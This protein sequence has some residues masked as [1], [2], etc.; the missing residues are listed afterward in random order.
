MRKTR[1]KF[2]LTALLASVASLT[3]IFAIFA[4][5][6]A[7]ANA[8]LSTELPDLVEKVL[9][10]V[11]NISSITIQRMSPN[12]HGMD[13]FF[14]FWG[15]PKEQPQTSLGSGFIISK[16]GYVITNNHV[17]EGADEVIVNLLDKKSYKARIIGKDPKLDLA[18]LRIRQKDGSV[19]ADLKPVTLG[20]SDK[21]RIAEP[22]FAVGNPFGLQHTVTTGIISAKNRTIG[23]GPLDNFLQTDASIN[24]GNSGGPLFNFKGE[25]IGIN[26]SIFS[27]TGQSAGLGFSI[28]VNEAKSSLEDLKRYG[29][30]PR[31]W[32]GILGQTVT[33]QLQAYYDL[34]SD[35]GVFVV[36]LV[37]R[38]PGDR[39]GLRQG[40]I[41]VAVE[42]TESGDNTAVERELYRKKP[43]DTVVLKVKR[44]GKTLNLDVKLDELPKLENLP[45][46]V[47]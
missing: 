28:P 17:V 2:F 40:D 20:E 36:N 43:T 35:K 29:R 13:D 21:V 39:S 32:L 42:G 27:R 7:G 6:N 34:P 25:V 23:L 15:V 33:P 31:P 24:P 9:P 30:V 26:T 11:V 18:L 46:G 44:G 45:Q 19:P 8:I 37:N 3:G 41:I 4:P 12:I 5:L 1:L 10:G 22:V 38:G 47:L 16:D 14:R